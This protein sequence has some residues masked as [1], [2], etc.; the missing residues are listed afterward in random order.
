MEKLKVVLGV[1]L[2]F[3]SLAVAWALEVAGSRKPEPSSIGLSTATAH[4]GR[5]Q[6]Q[7][8]L[9]AAQLSAYMQRLRI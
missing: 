6:R 4:V 7:F 3:H 1:Q 9:V 5:K 2:S 8:N